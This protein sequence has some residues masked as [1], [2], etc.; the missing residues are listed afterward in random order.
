MTA[1]EAMGANDRFAEDEDEAK[2]WREMQVMTR[3]NIARYV[4]DVRRNAVDENGQRLS[5]LEDI[6]VETIH[7]EPDDYEIVSTKEH[8]AR[9]CKRFA[10]AR[11]AER[12]LYDPVTA[13]EASGAIDGGGPA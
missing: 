4:Q 3:R 13:R 7:D 6:D 12:E 9:E 5:R 8:R 2:L 11:R 1:P 10:D